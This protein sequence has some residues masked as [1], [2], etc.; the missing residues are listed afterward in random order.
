MKTTIDTKKAWEIVCADAEAKQCV[1]TQIDTW[2]AE[3]KYP[4]FD[5][6]GAVEGHVVV[7]RSLDEAL[8]FADPSTSI[9]RDYRLELV[10]ADGT[11][12]TIKPYAMGRSRYKAVKEAKVWAKDIGTGA[13]TLTIYRGPEVYARLTRATRSDAWKY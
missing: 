12:T 11:R 9:S 1:V 13:G 2:T 10:E 3:I 8:S 7:T 6:D 5:E 4:N